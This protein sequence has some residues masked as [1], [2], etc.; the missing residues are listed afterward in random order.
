LQAT[1]PEWFFLAQLLAKTTD[2]MFEVAQ[3]IQARRLGVSPAP[4]DD[5][6]CH[7][8]DKN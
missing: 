8:R 3:Q 6:E 7:S 5:H 4:G 1:A 2:F